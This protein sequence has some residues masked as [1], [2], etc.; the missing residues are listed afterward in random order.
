MLRKHYEKGDLTYKV[1]GRVTG[2]ITEV[3]GWG[4]YN[5]NKR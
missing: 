1:S 5:W 4:V 3:A 2:T